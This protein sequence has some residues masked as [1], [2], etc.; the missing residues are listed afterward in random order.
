LSRSKFPS[1][2]Y[3]MVMR[4][5]NKAMKKNFWINWSVNPIFAFF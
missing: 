5:K 3:T 1:G 2:L 4:R